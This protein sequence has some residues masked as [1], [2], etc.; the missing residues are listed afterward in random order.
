M[1]APSPFQEAREGLR[2]LRKKLDAIDHVLSLMATLADSIRHHGEVPELEYNR[3]T[4]EV[5]LRVRVGLVPPVVSV[6]V[7]S[8]PE[9]A[10]GRLP[11]FLKPQPKPSLGDLSDRIQGLDASGAAAIGVVK[12]SNRPLEA[13]RVPCPCKGHDEMC[14]CQNR[15]PSETEGATTA[16]PDIA[17]DGSRGSR[18]P[19][20]DADATR[21][22]EQAPVAEGR[23]PAAAGESPAPYKTGDWTPEEERLLLKL[24][25]DGMDLSVMALTLNRR[26][27]G[28]AAKLRALLAKRSIPKARPAP[29][30]APVAPPPPRP[31]A[32]P[33]AA[34][35]VLAPRPRLEREAEARLEAAAS[36]DWPVARDLELVQRM[37]IG[38][39]AGGTAAAMEIVKDAVVARWRQLFPNHPTIEEQAAMLSVLGARVQSQ[40]E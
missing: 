10:E 40:G 8:A 32:P 22:G 2:A 9:P 29:E 12:P 35:P 5:A 3:E 14:P 13:L 39:G 4:G 7:Q 30:R 28:V 27:T 24:H 6:T 15:I 23:E 11:E 38:D 18:Q 36:D 1:S 34:G 20:A 21:A 16:D 17:G 37:A 26:G 19:Q 25:D 33:P 31:A